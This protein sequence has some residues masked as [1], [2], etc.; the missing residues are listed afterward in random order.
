MTS[1]VELVASVGDQGTRWRVQLFRQGHT[2]DAICVDIVDRVPVAKQLPHGTS[3]FVALWYWDHLDDDNIN[4]QSV[5]ACGCGTNEIS[6]ID[7]DGK[8]VGTLYIRDGIQ[9]PESIRVPDMT[10]SDRITSIVYQRQA[11]LCA[12]LKH[13]FTDASFHL[14]RVRRMPLLFYTLQASLVEFDQLDAPVFFERCLAIVDRFADPHDIDKNTLASVLALVSLG[15]VYRFDVNPG[16]SHE[17]QDFWT[18]LLSFPDPHLASFDCEDG[19][20]ALLEVFLC[21]VRMS[22]EGSS[23]RLRSLQLTAKRYT[24]FMGVVEL[25][26]ATGYGLHCITV[27]LD[28][29]TVDALVSDRIAELPASSHSGR[30]AESPAPTITLESTAYASGVWDAKNDTLVSDEAHMDLENEQ[31]PSSLVNIARVHS[32]ISMVRNQRMYGRLLSLFTCSYEKG[33]TTSLHLLFSHNSVFGVEASAFFDDPLRSC[34]VDVAIERPTSELLTDLD[35]HLGFF[36]Q[37]RLPLSA[38][39]RDHFDVREL[40]PDRANLYQSV[41]NKANVMR[42]APGVFRDHELHVLYP[43]PLTASTLSTY[44]HDCSYNDVCVTRKMKLGHTRSFKR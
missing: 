9:V 30:M 22:T 17:R 33:Q 31:V 16:L 28:S 20:K 6:M 42:I 34:T 38:L 24:P 25:K 4:A 32:P 10:K 12:P 36:P 21:F 3:G 23:V 37:C 8:Q 7:I 40:H 14:D 44:P 15:W 43:R 13:Q 19:S 11:R 5:V 39:E 41:K 18:S 26:N 35:D 29:T 27:L 2:H 1:T